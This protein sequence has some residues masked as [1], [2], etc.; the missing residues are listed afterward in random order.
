[1]DFFINCIDI[2]FNTH[3]ISSIY[4]I[5]FHT[6]RFIQC[7]HINSMWIYWFNAEILIQC[8]YID[9]IRIYWFNADIFIQCRN[10][11]SICKYIDSMQIYLFNTNFVYSLILGRARPSHITY[12]VFGQ[13]TQAAERLISTQ[14][15]KITGC[16][17]LRR[18]FITIG[19][20]LT[21]NVWSLHFAL[22][23]N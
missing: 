2:S 8:R 12:C 15:A 19:V 13:E 20:Q 21:Q 9:S 18:N 4:H 23:A 1:M 22:I 5:L 17:K 6:N 11:D 14:A 3:I 10:I 7:K 16:D